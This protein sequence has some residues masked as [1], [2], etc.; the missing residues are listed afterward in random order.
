MWPP[1][2]NGPEL[3]VGLAPMVRANSVALRMQ[4]L[5]YG[6]D[7]VYSE[8]L[9][10]QRLAK[11]RRVVNTDLD[12]VDFLNENDTMALRVVP[13]E[14]DRLVVQLGAGDEAAARQAA[15]HVSRDCAG[16]DLNMGCPKPFSTQGGMGAALLRDPDRAARCIRAM[17]DA[18]PSNVTVSAKIRMIGMEPTV[19]LCRALQAAGAQVIAVHCRYPNEQ[20][21]KKPPR[22]DEQRLLFQRLRNEFRV[23]REDV[24]LLANGDLYTR[25][26]MAQACEGGAD[27]VI[28]AR[29]ALLNCSVFFAE[30]RLLPRL[31][32]LRDY[33]T[34]CRR[35][36]AHHKNA[37]YVL[38]EMMA[39]RRH[40]ALTNARDE[41][42]LHL[43]ISNAANCHSMDAL[44]DL[45][46]AN[47]GPIFDLPKRH[48]SLVA[49]PDARTYADAYFADELLRP[50]KEPRLLEEES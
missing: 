22:L 9:V 39:K 5:A 18:L 2:K 33:I 20:P 6:A 16:V 32:V 50:A 25:D 1:T 10:A 41:L 21:P 36:D 15:L 11:T 12:T 31:V 45:V 29:P 4:A 28:I 24:P 43:T 17:R 34:F 44:T 37:K 35:Y 26:A 13:H 3:W 40:P 14:R 19:D 48:T 46:C 27:G 8:E 42:P 47:D 38:M 49:L 30:K 7:A 23:F